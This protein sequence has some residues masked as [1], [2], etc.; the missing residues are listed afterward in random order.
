[1]RNELQIIQLIER[2]LSNELS[3]EEFDTFTAKLKTSESLRN[4]VELQKSLL[5]GI[6]RLGVKQDIQRAKREYFNRRFGSYASILIIIVAVSFTFFYFNN[7]N[8]YTPK[9]VTSVEVVSDEPTP[10]NTDHS[11]TPTET[12]DSAEQKSVVSTKTEHFELPKKKFQYFKINQ[13]RDTTLKGREGTIIEIPSNSF[14]TNSNELTI[15][16]KEYYKMSD[17]VFSDLTTMTTNN[18]IIE[19]G[20]M[21][22]IEAISND[23]KRLE[24]K[25]DKEINLKFPFEEKKSDM[26]LF[27]G[28]TDQDGAV[29][30]NAVEESSLLEQINEI[31]EE[32]PSFGS[33]TLSSVFTIVE[34]MPRYPGCD[35][36]KTQAIKECTY[37][38][39]TNYIKK[40]IKYPEELIPQE[41]S[42]TVYIS[43]TIDE[44]GFVTNSR[45][46][47]GVDP[48]LDY[49]ALSVINTLPRHIPGRQRGKRVAVQ[50][51]VPIK[52]NVEG[53]SKGY[54]PE[55]IKTYNDSVKKVRKKERLNSLEV[56]LDAAESGEEEVSENALYDLEYYVFASSNLGWINCDRF[57]YDQ[58][59]KTNFTLNDFPDRAQVRIVFHS[60]KSL[61]SGH[62][63][64]EKY[65]FSRLPIGEMVTIFAIKKVNGVAYICLQETKIAKNPPILEFEKV[66]KDD[67][68]MYAK[69][70]NSIHG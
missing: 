41:V 68:K 62:W 29:R 46:L 6:E 33:D 18:E 1:M 14:N 32:E 59:D 36:V 24:L 12:T 4:E 27:T 67:I 57:I 47:R 65:H 20:G 40:N 50:F 66:S 31:Q 3:Q 54:T 9:E 21:L 42:G 64:N 16:L 58:R 2:Y 25:K 60:T 49:E 10:T 44:R 13:N 43:Y 39:V 7:N 26:Q 34:E 5:E 51:N 38:G 11:E 48:L 69:K 52:F 15:R 35:E 63:E 37:E 53:V 19:T 70:I 22:Y 17:M 28:E 61:M 45:I 30:W 23:G 55:E 56:K 8:E